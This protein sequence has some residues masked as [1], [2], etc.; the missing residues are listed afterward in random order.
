MV[1]FI[2][3]LCVLRKL[4]LVIYCF[5]YLLSVFLSLSMKLIDLAAMKSGGECTRYSN[6]HY[7]HPK[8]LIRS[9]VAKNMGDGWE[10]A[11]R[12]DRPPILTGR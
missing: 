3:F 7:G 1:G 8:N 11:R 5:I 2:K 9:G 10:T 12:L 4:N 6:A